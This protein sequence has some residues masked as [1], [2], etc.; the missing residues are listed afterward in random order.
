MLA[1][2]WPKKDI[3]SFFQNN[4]CST[5]DIKDVQN[6]KEQ[7]LSRSQIIDSVFEK[8]YSRDDG[9]LGQ[10]RSIL[11]SLIEWSNFDPY[12]FEN[13]NKLDKNEA[14]RRISHLKQ[15]Q[16]IRDAKLKE[17]QKIIARKNEEANTSKKTYEELNRQF[18]ML[19]L[20]K[21]IQGN[22]I[23]LQQR[24]YL[25]ESFLIDLCL[26]EKLP[27]TE[28]FKLTG[29]QIDGVVKFE[30]ENYIMEAKWHDWLTASNDL[31]HFAFKVEKKMYGRGIFISIN[32]YSH[33]SL[34]ALQKGSA[35][36]T[37]LF[38]GGDLTLV[39]EG[40]LSFKDMLDQKVK[41]AQTMGRIYVD[42]FSM[43]DKMGFKS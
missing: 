25:F 36:K 13:L 43:K 19:Y 5:Q 34:E 29:E 26:F 15:L 20:G 17:Q 14:I 32:G 37:V 31:Y 3:I 41:A 40:L 24:G 38:D 23:S 1:I 22:K 4:G 28:P 6:F 35:L 42:V 11:L 9:G 2:F 10:F 33:D 30:G 7:G 12:Y 8:L 39:M 16:E 18:T 27:V 21:D